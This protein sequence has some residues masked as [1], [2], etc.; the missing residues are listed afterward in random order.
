MKHL[1]LIPNNVD[2]WNALSASEIA[3]I[4][5]AHTALQQEIRASGEF[6]EAH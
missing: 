3:A 1:L 2:T 6:V 5:Q 4:M